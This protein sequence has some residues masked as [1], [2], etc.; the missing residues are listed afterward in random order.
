MN[1]QKT[2]DRTW[3]NMDNK[4]HEV[5][6]ILSEECAEV[7]QAVSNGHTHPCFDYVLGETRI[8]CNPRGYD[9]HEDTGWNPNKIVEV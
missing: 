8:V 9:G 7:I 3:V 6:N 4:L 5:M 1:L 2:M